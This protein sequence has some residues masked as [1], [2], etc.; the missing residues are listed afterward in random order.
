M[1]W[2]KTTMQIADI[3]NKQTP[4]PRHSMLMELIHIKVKDQQMLI[5]ER[6]WELDLFLNHI[7]Q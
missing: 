7:T 5:Q 1:E 4:G 2:I 6:L 3:G